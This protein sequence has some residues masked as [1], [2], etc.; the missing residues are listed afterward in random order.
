MADVEAPPP[1]PTDTTSSTP[2]EKEEFNVWYYYVYAFSMFCLVV[3]V[4]SYLTA[5]GLPFLSPGWWTGTLL[6]ITGIYL[7]LQADLIVTYFRLMKETQRF[8][9]NNKRFKGGLRRQEGQ[10]RKLKKAQAAF[11][12]LDKQFGGNVDKAFEELEEMQASAKDKIQQSA[13]A[14]LSMYSADVQKGQDRYISKGPKITEAIE[15]LTALYCRIYPA[16][17]ER[18][19]AMRTGIE[20]SD[21]FERDE[22][23]TPARFGKAFQVALSVEDVSNVEANVRAV[24]AEKGRATIEKEFLDGSGSFG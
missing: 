11:E 12:K 4:V 20:A 15:M 2:V 21:R 3:G 17:F 9:Q 24:M 1:P 6:L 14:L 19:E 8:K 22:G 13:N 18:V 7:P 5:D 16:F 10:I 23:I